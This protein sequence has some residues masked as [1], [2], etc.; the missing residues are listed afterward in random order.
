MTDSLVFFTGDVRIRSTPQYK[1]DDSNLI[2]W[3]HAGEHGV[4]TNIVRDSDG[5]SHRWLWVQVP[6]ADGTMRAGCVRD[7]TC[8]LGWDFTAYG[9][10]IVSSA[11][12]ACDVLPQMVVQ[13]PVAVP[14]ASPAPPAY[15][16]VPV[17]LC[18]CP[19]RPC[20][21]TN[22]YGHTY[23]GVA[24]EGVDCAGPAGD[25]IKAGIRGKVVRVMRSAYGPDSFGD[26]GLPLNNAAA[27][28]DIRW[29]Y[30][31]GNHVILRVEWADLPGST[32]SA[33]V[34]ANLKRAHAYVAFGHMQNLNVAAGAMVGA[35]DVLGWRGHA[36]NANGDH[37]HL[38]TRIS[39]ALDP[40][41]PFDDTV[42]TKF[43]PHWLYDLP[44]QGGVYP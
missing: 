33:L 12:L 32:Q 3:A 37:L 24:H 21:N 8:Y 17:G 42:T 31:L 6:N 34:A 11:K 40:P 14:V 10:G 9:L 43:N 20:T 28:N 39:D 2:A 22:D 13:P 7:D 18:A 26:R 4:V 27:L 36:G 30:G 41:N 1:P 25:A 29:G 35:G 38:E 23:A 44:G 15:A 16:P 5:A 19:V